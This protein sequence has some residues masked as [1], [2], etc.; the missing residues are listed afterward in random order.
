MRTFLTKLI[1]TLCL[2]T[3]L[4]V[5]ACASATVLPVPV[6]IQEA[7][8]WCFAASAEMIFRYL[9]YPNANAAG[10]Y[11]CG[12]VG[13]QGGICSIKCDVCLDGGRTTQRVAEIMQMYADFAY[14]VTGYANPGVRINVF[15]IL[16]SRQI[17]SQIDQRGPIL[18]GISPG[19]IRYPAGL[20]ISQHAVVIVG[21]EG[22]PESLNVVINDPYPYPPTSDPYVLNSA[23]K[24]QQGQ[25]SIP[26]RIFV[27]KFNY[28]NSVTFR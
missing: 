14:R 23:F 28:R 22:T 5:P 26:L 18:A 3:G 1:A 17:I 19:Q 9:G 2:T 20:G 25:Y 24:M 7:P 21:Y 8:E 16:S 27:G 11:Q 13:A 15:G 12:I 6:I 10:N 4:L